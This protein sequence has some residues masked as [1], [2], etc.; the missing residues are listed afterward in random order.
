MVEKTTTADTH[1]HTD[2]QKKYN[3]IKIRL[4]VA[5]IIITFAALS[6]IAFSTIAPVT[7]SF[8][9]SLTSNPYLQFLIFAAI[10]G[11]ALSIVGFPL[12]FYGGYILEH[13]FNLS[14]QSLFR[15][16]FEKAKASLIGLVI[17]IPVALVFF[18]F[19]RS[20]GDFWWFYFSIFIFF[21]SVFLARI[22]PVVIF[23]LFY[24]FRE[25]DNEKI[26]APLI[27]I[28]KRFNIRIQGIYSFNMSRDTKKANAA[29]TG[30]GKSKR[31][32]LSDT[33]IEDF[34]PDEIVTV[35]A[36][37]V[38][39]YKKKHII[40]NLIFSTVIIFLSFYICSIAYENTVAAMGYLSISRPAAIPVLLLYLS[41][42]SL[43]LMPVTNIISR[44]YEVEAD[45]FALEATEDS[46]SFISTMERLAEMNL[47]DP[48]P[49]PLVEFFFYS[50]PSIKKR[51]EFARHYNKNGNKG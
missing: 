45:T 51:I 44:H 3:R 18:Y 12:D 36:H 28:S 24:K 42:F 39:H 13:R 9:L 26:T 6:I 49:H 15:W 27:K 2:K 8:A 25:L 34:P 40:K 31:I 29:F 23:P 43:F 33:L 17:G 50:H 35:F 22:A 46:E 21:I 47:A 32:I 20:T 5:D 30:L 4:S 37:E 19:L 14:N 11:G 41:I 48:S 10:L 1:L 16:L 38:G 7:E